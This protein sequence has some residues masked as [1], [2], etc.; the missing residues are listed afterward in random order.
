[1]LVAVED[2]LAS[3]MTV[4]AD[5]CCCVAAALSYFAYYCTLI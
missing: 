4:V 3:V 2:L 1:M 5:N